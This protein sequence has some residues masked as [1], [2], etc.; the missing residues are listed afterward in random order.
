MSAWQVIERF[1]LE[2]LLLS[3]NAGAPG[4]QFSAGSGLGPAMTWNIIRARAANE[5]SM[6]RNIFHRTRGSSR[7]YTSWYL[8]FCLS[9]HAVINVIK[10]SAVSWN[11]ESNY[12]GASCMTMALSR[13]RNLYLL[14]GVLGLR[15]TFGAMWSEYLA[16]QCCYYCLT[17]LA[18]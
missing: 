11:S 5:P 9:K 17:W 18:P 6:N 2:K 16:I 15:G 10:S 14:A 13:M 3:Y 4:L 1:Y 12:E 7:E 8:D